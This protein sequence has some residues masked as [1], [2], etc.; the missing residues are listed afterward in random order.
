M[1]P[2]APAG[3]SSNTYL[4]RSISLSIYDQNGN[5]VPI[6]STSN[7]SIEIIIPRDPNFIMPFMALQ[8]VTTL[9]S[10]PHQ[11]LYNLHYV[12]ITSTLSISVHFEMRPHNTSL[13]YLLIYKF[14]GAPQL[15]SS[16]KVIDGWALFCPS[17]L[18]IQFQFNVHH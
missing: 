13:A 1:Q 18:Y 6:R 11:H 7:Q 8:N 10:T 4:S 14:D 2:L 9:S 17:S 15:N 12:N 5:E 3:D 16:I